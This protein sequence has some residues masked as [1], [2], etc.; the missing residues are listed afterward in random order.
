MLLIFFTIPFM[1]NPKLSNI[2]LYVIALGKYI[3]LCQ[4]QYKTNQQLRAEE[5][6][7][8]PDRTFQEMSQFGFLHQIGVGKP[9]VQE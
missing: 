3:D 8:Q 7:N 4:N 2:N 5:G 9:C 6:L 1:K